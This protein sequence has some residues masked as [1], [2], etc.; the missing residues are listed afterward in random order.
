MN[1]L[2]SLLSDKKPE[3]DAPLHVGQL[4]LPER[5]A[6]DAAFNAVF[7]RHYFTNHGPLVESLDLEIAEYLGV[8]HAVCMTSGTIA[9][10]VACKALDLKGTVIVPSFTF[11]ATVQALLWS[12]LKPIFCDVD[13]ESHNIDT[14]KIQAL[15]RE[16][17]CAIVGVHLWGRPCDVNLLQSIAD[18]NNLK[19]IFDA[20]H[21]FGVT[22]DN[23]K[24]GN[25]GDLEIFSFHATKILNA[26]EGGCVTTNSPDIAARLKTIRNFHSSDVDADVSLRINGKMSEAQ[27]AMAQL[28]LQ[29]LEMNIANNKSQWNTYYNELSS[30]AGLKIIILD[31]SQAQNYQYFVCE[32]IEEDF[33][34]SRDQLLELLVAE[35]IQ[36]RKYFNPP[37]HALNAIDDFTI[38]TSLP[39]TEKLCGR[40]L[41]LPL[42]SSGSI[43]NAK[44]VSNI[45]RLANE[46]SNHIK[47]YFLA[48]NTKDF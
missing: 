19:L 36:A 14:D 41:Q 11:C 24:V 5:K 39:I 12:G 10:M 37:A 28:S 8:N 42:G 31:N 35:N 44:R 33:G 45:I 27:A 26:A 15:I 48:E 1:N 32:I 47:Q 4:Y 46:N 29:N 38:W 43:K 30:I 9:I 23:I 17:T 21:A 34:L 25:F 3:F 7:D 6:F 2:F 18:K 22:S 20:C 40:V 16:D 13:N